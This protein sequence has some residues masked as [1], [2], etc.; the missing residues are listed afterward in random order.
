MGS[1]KHQMDL[2]FTFSR[3]EMAKGIQLKR[4]CGQ[5]FLIADRAKQDTC[6]VIAPINDA[7]A[8]ILQAL[9]EG[10]PT[11]EGTRKIPSGGSPLDRIVQRI[12]GAYE[13]DAGQ[14]RRDLIQ[15][16]ETLESKGY[17]VCP[18]GEHE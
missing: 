11:E 10:Q 8:L 9:E 5:Y 12:C 1:E 3:C 6:P 17:L 16:C 15:F 13:V 2:D 4:I 7:G 14:A 18:E